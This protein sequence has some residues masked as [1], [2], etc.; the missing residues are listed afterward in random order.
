M[1]AWLIAIAFFF[2]LVVQQL[3]LP[4]LV[5]FLVA[6]FVLKGLGW[7]GGEM[8][9][10][11]SDL[12]VTLMLF[13]IG[14]KLR[15]KSLLRPEIWLGTSLHTLITAGLFASIF[16]GLG[17]L[18]LPMFGSLN[19]GTA[20]LLAF[21][22]S[23]SSTVFAVKT[24]EGSGDMGALHGRVAVGILV[25]QDLLAV[26]FLTASTGKIPSWW[27]VGLLVALLALR[28]FLGWVMTR[29][30]HGEL[31]AL[32][33]LFL[34][35]VL[36]AKG[37]ES[38]GLKA[39]LG[40]LFVG[41]LVGQFA[42]A[43]ELSKSLIGI[44]DLLLVGFF[45]SI[46]L[47]GLPEWRGV[48]VALLIVLL[49]PFKIALFFALLTRCHLRARTAWMGGLTLGSYSEFGLI[50][51][52]L[53]VG[54]NWMPAE[55]L[56]V[57]A[58]ALSLS[59]LLAAPLN[60]KAELFYDRLSDWLHRFETTGQHPDDLP[61][62]LN[63]EQIAIFGM[64]RVGL[65]AYQV[66]SNRFSGKVIGFDRDPAQVEIHREAGRNVVLADATDSDFWHRVQFKDQIELVVLAM[67]KHSANLHAAETLKRNDYQGVVAA[68]A[69]FDDEMKELRAL[70]L[71]TVFNLYNEA[72]AGFAQHVSKVFSQQRPDLVVPLKSKD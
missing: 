68:T 64:G 18:G 11:I 72:G 13:S 33:G 8:L 49:L 69:K 7:S 24:L 39:D 38:V 12:G 31:I 44:T 56:V 1:D 28:P 46:G 16:L 6:G 21:A 19:W 58:I 3:G 25:M 20:L 2:G 5:G 59:I 67:P 62:T 42:K 35:L 70:G 57:V 41:V 40:A 63:G 48:L 17:I 50:V 47:E 9:Q 54:K 55:W 71:D 37:F 34:A 65:S 61:V 36:G 45:L 30:G 10:T 29:C 52:A 4:P 32:C 43:K 26:L 15:L 22:L 53:A 66:M 14:L 23:F 51:M 27:A 60:R